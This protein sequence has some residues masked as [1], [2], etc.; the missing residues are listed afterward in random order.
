MNHFTSYKLFLP[1][2]VL[3]LLTSC[4][5]LHF[6]QQDSY[7]FFVAGHTYGSPSRK[8]PGLHPPFVAD[9]DTIK[10]HSNISFGVLTGDIV[11]YS[12]DTFWD[13]VDQELSYLNMPIHF[14]AGNHD[15]GHKSIYKNR[16]GRTYYTFTQG[17]DLFLILNPGL[18]GWNIWNEQLDF[19]K[20]ALKKTNK[21]EHIFVFC[22]QVLWSD[23]SDPRN[24]YK[25]NSYDGRSPTIN[26]WTEIMPLFHATQ[27]PVYLFAGDVGANYK[28]KAFSSI[29]HKN[30]QLLAS[31]MGNK[32][33]DNYL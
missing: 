19:L 33:T 28:T 30:V 1:L 31:G 32:H 22:H 24:I 11:Y 16:Y 12:R 27:R 8:M 25:P 29:Q 14:A 18:G 13:K 15:E 20:T 6:D 17:E 26:F 10:S 3:L 9:F 4:R 5:S 7:C 2:I 21:Y 23:P